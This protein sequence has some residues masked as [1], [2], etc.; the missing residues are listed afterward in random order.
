MPT[1]EFSWADCPNCKKAGLPILPVRYT[2][3]PKSIRAK[4]PQ[5]ISGAGVTEVALSEHNYGLRTLREGW[6][7][8]FYVKGARGSN[9]WEVYKVTEDGRLWKQSLP[10]PSEL[11]VHPSCAQKGTAVP[12]DIIAIE[13]PEKCT[14]A[15]IAFS[16]QTWIKDTFKR[17]ESDA[18]LR[19]QRMQCI[20]PAKWVA[21]TKPPKGHAA[22]ATEQNIDEII[23]YMPG[24]DH[25]LLQP[26]DQHVSDASGLH[27]QKVIRLESTR[28]PLHIRQASPD[29]AGVALAALMNDVGKV[30]EGKSR[31]PMILA[32][33]DGVGNVHELNGFR[34]DPASW[35]DQYAANEHVLQV[36][37]MHDIDTA[38]Q[39]VKSREEHALNDQEDMA[40]QAQEMSAFGQPG[41][42]SALA[43]QRA[44]ALASADPFRAAQINTYYD[45]MDWMSA[46]NIPGSYQRQIVQMGQ[47]SSAGSPSSSTPYIGSYRDQVM[48]SARA[49]AQAQPG[50]HD[51]NLNQMTAYAWSTYEARLKRNEIEAFREHYQALQSVVYQLQET[52]SN[53]V[54]QWIKA[55]LLLNTLED[56]YPSDPHDGL[57]FETI[58]SEA[59][60][61]LASTPKGKAIVDGLIDQWD[62]TQPGS[63]IWRVVAMN[64]L[65]A[66]H[67]LGDVLKKAQAEKATPLEKGIA[68]VAAFTEPAKKLTKYYKDLS[69]LAVETDASK[70]T[71]LG[72]LFRRLEVDKFGMTVGDAIFAKFRVNQ[73]GDVVG[74]KIIQTLLLQ[75]AGIPYDDAIVL[76]RKQAELEKLSRLDTIKRLLVARGALRSPATVGTP[77]AT[78]EL[79]E[80]W[81]KVK[82]TDDG[83][84]TL[85]LGRI[86][87]VAGLLEAVNFA[88]LL[89]GAPDKNTRMKLF[90]S[91]A[92]LCSSVITITMSPYYGALKS[93]VRSQKWKLVGGGLSS[94]SV[95]VTAWLDGE[96]IQVDRKEGQYDVATVLGFKMM[97]GLFSGT[98]I[99]IDA[100]STAA[101]VLKKL[102][103]RYGSEVVLAAVE[104]FTEQ[105]AKAA[106]LRAVGYLVSWEA[107][108]GLILL[109]AL[110][111]WLTPDALEAWCSRC[112]FGTGEEARFRISDHSVGRYSDLKEQEKYFTDAM[113]KLS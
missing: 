67:E 6:L 113:T 46:N 93:S 86:A 54:G 107:T 89:A 23:E 109:Q 12:M 87:V 100:V 29:S 13:Q 3:L 102:A 18:A 49:Y 47:M 39:I 42:Q 81:N 15:Y 84:K 85:R 70:I 28:Y 8:L 76:V 101:P 4:M 14:E 65:D 82:L 30:K 83:A 90:A 63:L 55:P 35:F 88:H 111:D 27:D 73:V 110:A 16:E 57:V 43:A 44:K 11:I 105:M 79:Y 53:D 91:G 58:V 50:F 32:L 64:Q 77:N 104:T 74:E 40:A 10:L 37:A 94:V 96:Q 38:Q 22:T 25:T 33:W 99:L 41:A 7:Y 71:P 75:R 112:A 9:Y 5:G 68:K 69:R 45:D 80:V 62:P 17:Y 2:V 97:L 31:P 92:S 59:V 52:R 78:V 61:G 103:T 56:C 36:A 98:A 66:R 95:F 26:R 1:T 34:N 19:K 24:F 106:A 21:A 60:F 48:S 72:A 20:E 108:I 51:R